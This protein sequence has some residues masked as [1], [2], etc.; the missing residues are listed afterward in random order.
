MPN[1]IFGRVHL[2]KNF[3]INSNA[4]PDMANLTEG[5]STHVKY[6]SFRKVTGGG[7]NIV[8]EGKSTRNASPRL[9]GFI[10]KKNSSLNSYA[11]QKAL[12]AQTE[13]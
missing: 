5:P 7:N 10:F 2:K 8:S 3:A 1:P 4:M 13:D 9:V 12:R 6:C 11:M